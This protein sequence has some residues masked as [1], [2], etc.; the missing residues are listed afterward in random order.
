M[1]MKAIAAEAIGTFILTL[2]VI[3]SLN[4]PN[5]PIPTPLIAALALG[6][7]VYTLGPI[8]GAHINPAVTIAL[9]SIR[10]IDLVNALGYILCQFLGAGFAMLVSKIY[11]SELQAQPVSNAAITGVGELIGAAIFAFGIV[12]VVTGRVPRNFSGVVVGLSLL[13]GISIAAPL[14]NGVLNP[15]VALGIGSFSLAYVWGPIVGGVLGA[16]L[17]RLFSENDRSTV[18]ENMTD[19]LPAENV[20]T[21]LSR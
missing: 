4:N 19:K 21:A 17:S 9:W 20:K 15:A 2:S 8:S 5:F 11:F 13:L 14:S 10:K 1:E 6:L 12:A 18:A 16:V 7:T 3:I